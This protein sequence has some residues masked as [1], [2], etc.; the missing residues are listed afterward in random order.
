MPA[1]KNKQIEK[2]KLVSLLILLNLKT[3]IK[4]KKEY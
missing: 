2:T 1:N 4:K 3:E